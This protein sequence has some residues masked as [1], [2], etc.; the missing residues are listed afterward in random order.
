MYRNLGIHFPLTHRF[1]VV[2]DDDVIAV[3]KCAE[4]GGELWPVR[5]WQK[6]GPLL[7]P[8]CY[9]R[10]YRVFKRLELTNA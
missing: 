4:C 5:R 2:F 9:Q 3:G 8:S 10:V 7:C 6:T 1:T